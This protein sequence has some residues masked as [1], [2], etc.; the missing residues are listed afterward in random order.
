MTLA[1]L[2]S[3]YADVRH[4]GTAKRSECSPDASASVTLGNACL[5]PSYCQRPTLPGPSKSGEA[6]GISGLTRRNNKIAAFIGV[7]DTKNAGA[8]VKAVFHDVLDEG[9]D[10][11]VSA[12]KGALGP[13]PNQW[14]ESAGDNTRHCKFCSDSNALQYTVPK[15]CAS[16]GGRCQRKRAA[17]LR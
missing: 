4:K 16:V 11:K 14:A 17:R 9:H 6:G 15:A 12:S 5:I 10:R 1:A 8:S 2:P 7:P 13:R 3:N